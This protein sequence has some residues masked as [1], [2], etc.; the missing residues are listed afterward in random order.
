M[1]ERGQDNPPRVLLVGQ[2]Q[3]DMG[4]LRGQLE[5]LGYPLVLCDE[6]ADV[7]EIVRSRSVDLVI[8]DVTS[9]G[10]EG[11]RA[12]RMI[13]E[14]KPARE[15]PV[16]LATLRADHETRTMGAEAGADGFLNKPIEADEL[17][18]QIGLVYRT[19]R[20]TAEL[21]DENSRAEELN[22]KLMT[23]QAA[24]DRELNLAHRLQGSLL[25]QELPRFEKVAFAAG[26]RASGVV[27]GDFYDVFRLDERHAGFYVADAIGHGVPAALLTIFV[28]KGIRTKEIGTNSYRLLT[29]GEVLGQLNADIIEAALSDTP[30]VTMFYGCIDL[31]TREVEYSSGGHPWPVLVSAD[32]SAEAVRGEGPLLGVFPAEF[33]TNKIT[34]KPLDRLVVY[35][36]GV[37][38]ARDPNGLEGVDW[39][40]ELLRRYA[41]SPIEEQ[42]TKVMDGL[43]GERE[44]LRDDTTM[45][46]I[47]A[48][49]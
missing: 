15:M 7:P 22:S 4:S 36:D 49:G 17:W 8:V 34:L 42:V 25:P 39:M 16:L 3:S 27:S 44:H 10:V 9:P 6:S 30:F 18:S 40:K 48:T 24:M 37:E 31:E 43:V 45:L 5:A 14:V 11:V 1:S 29:P 28:K 19:C 13:K 35:S 33:T 47:H 23:A 41:G 20:L 21:R 46:L 12:C 26:L 32:G 38:D 2:G